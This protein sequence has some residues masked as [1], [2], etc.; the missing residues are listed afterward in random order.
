MACELVMPSNVWGRKRISGKKI[1]IVTL[2]M[3]GGSSKYLSIAI[4]NLSYTLSMQR[5][6][7]TML[8]I[9]AVCSHEGA[10]QR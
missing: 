10:L 6:F 5:V 7:C 1:Y 4:K 9:E 8:A 2:L 3:E